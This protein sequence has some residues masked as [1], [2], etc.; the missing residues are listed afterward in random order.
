VSEP[1]ATQASMRSVPLAGWAAAPTPRMAAGSGLSGSSAS[2]QVSPSGE[3]A[4]RMAVG[5][6]P[7][8]AACPG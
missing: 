8:P 7:G 4:T 5:V 3:V 1:P 2:V 6:A